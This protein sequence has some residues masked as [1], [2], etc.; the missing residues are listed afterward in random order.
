[1]IAGA[2]R[3]Q[4]SHHPRRKTRV[5]GGLFPLTA[6]R[7]PSPPPRCSRRQTR[8]VELISRHSPRGYVDRII[9]LI[10]N[11]VMGMRRNIA[12][13][14]G[15]NTKVFLY[16][17]WGAEHLE[18]TLRAALIR[19]RDRWDDPPYL[20]RIIFS[21]MIQDEVLEETGY[22]IAPYVMDDEFPTIEVDLENR[23]VNRQS[24]EMFV[25]AR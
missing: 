25:A 2:S 9:S 13:D 7:R 24:F 5:P 14:Y 10:P 12:L 20:A 3:R 18:D 15:A 23:T 16:T 6:C 19:G 8:T 17:H 1:M 21:E 11:D 4:G 22:G